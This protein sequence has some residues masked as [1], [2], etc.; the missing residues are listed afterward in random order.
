MV[1]IC[2]CRGQA[3]SR[4]S[5]VGLDARI[6]RILDAQARMIALRMKAQ[7]GPPY[8]MELAIR[9]KFYLA[10]QLEVYS[11]VSDLGSG[12]LRD[13]GEIR[14]IASVLSHQLG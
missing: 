2:T 9:L 12:L 13:T 7:E 4:G 10:R 11:G 6:P 8:L 14:T 5:V 3:S 1:F